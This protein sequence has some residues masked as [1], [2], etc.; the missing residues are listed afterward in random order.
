MAS[1]PDLSKMSVAELKQLAETLEIANAA[2][3]KKNELME[4]ITSSIE[5]AKQNTQAPPAEESDKS[6]ADKNKRQRFKKPVS[7]EIV[8]PAKEAAP[9]QNKD[10]N[11]PKQKPLE[12]VRITENDLDSFFPPVPD[13]EQPIIEEVVDKTAQEPVKEIVAKTEAPRNQHPQ[14]SPPWYLQGCQA[15]CNLLRHCNP[16]Q[17]AQ[18]HAHK[19]PSYTAPTKHQPPLTLHYWQPPS[20]TQL[21]A[22]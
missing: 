17:C 13:E 14:S 4:A 19:M 3:L 5:L 7:E 16:S 20:L 15:R 12:D 8:T 6:N 22:P 1:Q 10:R 9:P 11:F 18:D 2:K 21:R